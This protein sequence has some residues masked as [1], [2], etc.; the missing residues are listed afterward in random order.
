MTMENLIER[1]GCLLKVENLWCLEECGI[2]NTCLLES[3]DVFP[4]YYGSVPDETRPRF[5][6]ILAGD[7][8]SLE[9]IS[10]MAQA[11]RHN[12]HDP[13]DAALAEISLRG[14]TCSAVRIT[15][16]EDYDLIRQ[17]QETFRDAGLVLKKKVHSINNEEAIIK[18]RK[19]FTLVP[20]PG[21][22]FMD[23][24]NADIGYFAVDSN[25]PWD[26]FASLI[27][28]LRNNWTGSSFDAAQCFIYQK[29]VI[30]DL[31]RIYSKELTAD[32]LRQLRK[33]YLSLGT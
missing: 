6:Y 11:V 16:I 10:R 2:P 24:K 25:Q 23:A 20:L 28:Q 33:K 1:Y 4:A 32:M 31:V 27:R 30:T 29:G 19:F 7:K 15:G 22:L 8:Y 3:F 12:F 14:Q 26:H 13:F 21:D 17:L 5:V 9:Q 18:I